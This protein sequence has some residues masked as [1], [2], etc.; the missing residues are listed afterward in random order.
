MVERLEDDSDSESTDDD[1]TLFLGMLTSE[2]YSIDSDWSTLLIINCTKVDF[3]L[4]TGA[5]CIVLNR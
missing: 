2:M 1:D 3:Q 5:K 4:D